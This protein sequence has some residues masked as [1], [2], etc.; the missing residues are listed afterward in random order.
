MSNLGTSVLALIVSDEARASSFQ[1]VFADLL[2][3]KS[4]ASVKDRLIIE[5][6]TAVASFLKA[7]KE[8]KDLNG[9]ILDLALASESS[10]IE[11]KALTL[12]NDLQ[13]PTLRVSEKMA[14]GDAIDRKILIGKWNQL[15]DQVE[16]FA[17]RG[18]RVHQRKLCFI[19]IRYQKDSTRNGEEGRR[20]EVV[21]RAITYD[22]SLG[23]C[24]IVSMEDWDDV[25]QVTVMIGD[26]PKPIECTIAWKLPWG[27]NPWKMPGIGVEFNNI[28]EELKNYLNSFLKDA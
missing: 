15:M 23:G 26:F 25:N 8:R 5:R 9:V 16:I 1:K 13:I 2:D 10:E 28:T 20:I 17:P 14:N 19:K 4:K 21:S 3:D 12:L 27:A 22:V 18:L 24:F 6:F 7:Q 11:K